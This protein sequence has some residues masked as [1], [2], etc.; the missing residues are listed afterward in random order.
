MKPHRSTR[1]VNWFTFGLIGLALLAVGA[2]FWVTNLM[3]S[4]QSYRS[5]LA[6]TPP[7]PGQALGT[8]LTRRLV[9][10]LIDALRYDTSINSSVMPFL[11]ELRAQGASASMHSQPPSF[12]APGWTTIL[13][14][15]WPDIND[16]QLFNP[17]D[18]FSARAFTQD[19]IFTAAQRSGL[20]TAVSGYSWFEGML[21]NSGV[22]AGFYTPGENNAA[23]SEVVAA[24]LPWLTEDYQLVLIH[25]DQV[26]Y[27]GHHE[28]GPRSPNWNA[29]A[30][31]S[32]GMLSEIV[33]QLDLTQD[34]V[35][36]I[37]DHGQIDRGGHGG[38]EPV[39]LVEP[40]L[41]SG[42]GVIPGS[43]GDVNMVDIAPTLAALLG[44]NIP[45]SNQG[46]V[47]TK[48]LTLTSEQDGTIQDAL[49]AQQ[50]QLFTAY[51]T[52]IGS[53]ASMGDGEIVSATQIA[54]N[55]ARAG[56]LA[57]ERVWRNVVAALL[58]IL[59]G[60]LLILRKDRRILWLMA[61]ALLYVLLFNL[62]YAVIDGHTYSLASV[63][64]TTWLITYSATT[65]AV[66]VILGW[67]VSMFGLSA[68]KAGPRKA[69]E[70]ALGTIWFC[71]YLLALPILLNFAINGFTV[72]WTLPE[73][74]TLFIGLLSLIQS[75]IVAAVGLLLVGL[76]AGIAWLAA[77][78]V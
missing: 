40:F 2:Y 29:A 21:L 47:L 7:V 14:G 22:D 66:A 54:L 68:F 41:L 75:M 39:T 72:T 20:N 31:R 76:S 53:T 73:F 46:H 45:A 63:E 38:P 35:L 27:A 67:L 18:E 1:K 26:D 49:K 78:R 44:T 58:A 55:Q 15:A 33:A 12:S 64:S 11:N 23:D 30:T 37:S 65:A 70:I 3:G 24:A 61:G 50:S 25:L 28:G 34:T 71:I 62:R 16:S 59:P 8:P 9:V 51:T 13:T 32:D 19:D 36:V 56:R 6:N 69:A 60:Y 77:R 5:P 52:A 57:S 48:M 43:Y 10:V 42:A 74:Y 4:A 17:P